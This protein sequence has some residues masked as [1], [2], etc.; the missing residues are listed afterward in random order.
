MAA[1]EGVDQRVSRFMD[2][3]IVG[4]ATENGVMSTREVAKHQ[5]FITCWVEG[6]GIRKRVR[7]DLQ[8]VPRKAPADP[9]SQ[10]VF[11]ASSGTNDI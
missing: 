9:A 1:A 7:G 3:D 11:E 2:Y 4:E 5:G 8:L 10:A 6:F